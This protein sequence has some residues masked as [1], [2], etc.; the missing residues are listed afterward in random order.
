MDEFNP[1]QNIQGFMVNLNHTNE[2]QT[3]W[4]R[5][6]HFKHFRLLGK[7]EPNSGFIGKFYPFKNFQ[8]FFG[9]CNPF[10]KLQDILR[11]FSQIKTFPT[12][13]W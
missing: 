4:G 8:D 6:T 11:K 3:F 1:F 10:E 5:L 7:V 13:F 9:K 2:F 12:F